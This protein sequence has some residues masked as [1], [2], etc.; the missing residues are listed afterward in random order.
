MTVLHIF[1]FSEFK[2]IYMNISFKKKWKKFRNNHLLNNILISVIVPVYNTEKWIEEC[3]FSVTSQSIREIEIICINDGSTDK[4]K[5]IL[6]KIASFESRIIIIDQ[7]NKGLAAT[8]NVGLNFAIGKY[9]LF[10]DSDDMFQNNTFKEL[11][12]ITKKQNFE[13]IYFD[14]YLLFMPGMAY[15]QFRVNY[16]RRKKSYGHMTGKDLFS[17][18]YLNERFS[19]SACLMMINRFWLNYNKIKFIEGII[20]EDN[21]F[22]IQVMMKAIQTYHINK[23]YY[24]YRIRSNS[25]MSSELKPIHLYSRLIGYK[26]LIKLYEKEKLSNYQQKAL[27]KFIKKI[28]WH[29]RNLKKVIN[30][31]EWKI[32]SEKKNI[33]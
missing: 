14:A 30:D 16:Y 24:I 20:Y 28:E 22:S 32:F 19:D 9:I 13:V 3:L 11:I 6:E 33:R 23:Q 7:E 4:S 17:N 29:I 27:F 21:I 10:L 8:R 1:F 5:K 18:I 2:N 26:E 31:K 12:N 25:I 15:D